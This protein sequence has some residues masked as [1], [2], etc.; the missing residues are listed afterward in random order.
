MYYI[1]KKN[2]KLTKKITFIN[3]YLP[4]IKEK[5]YNGSELTKLEKYMI[6]L[7]EKNR[8]GLEEIMK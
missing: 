6:I 7:N 4:I 5:Y 2:E 8:E 3:I 1:I